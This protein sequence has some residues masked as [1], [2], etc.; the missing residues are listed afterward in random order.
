MTQVVSNSKGARDAKAWYNLPQM[1]FGSP[2][3]T[4]AP[5]KGRLLAAVVL[6]GL[7]TYLPYL[8]DGPLVN[9]DWDIGYR[10][11]AAPGYWP[12]YWSWFA[13]KNSNFSNRPVAPLIFA[14]QAKWFGY[15]APGYIALT[16]C[17]WL[18]AIAICV[19]SFGRAFGPVFAG[20]FTLLAF[21][22]SMASTQIFNPGMQIVGTSTM[23][24]WAASL[25][26]IWRAAESSRPGRWLLAS[27]LLLACAFLI[28]EL[29]LPLLVFQMFVPWAIRDLSGSRGELN[30]R[31]YFLRYLLPPLAIV[32]CVALLQKVVVPQ[33]YPVDSRLRVSPV[34]ALASVFSWFL[35][36]TV[37]LPTLW[38]ESLLYLPKMLQSP[39]NWLLL[40]ALGI[41]V[42]MLW[43]TAPAAQTFDDRTRQMQRR[44]S[45][46]AMLATLCGGSLYFMT[47]RSAF[48]W[49]LENRGLAST[50]V[51]LACCLAMAASLHADRRWVRAIVSMII[52][53]NAYSFCVQR[54]QY[55]QGAQVQRDVLSALSADAEQAELPQDSVLFGAVPEFL[56]DNFNDAV[57]FHAQ[58]DFNPASRLAT[59]DRVTV[60]VVMNQ[61]TVRDGRIQIIDD[62]R[63]DVSHYPRTEVEIDR[64][65]CFEYI[66]AT[67]QHRLF[68]V[69][70]VAHLRELMQAVEAKEPNPSRRPLLKPYLTDLRDLAKQI[71]R[72][73]K[74]QS[75]TATPQSVELQ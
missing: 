64:V 42:A 5:S 44:L 11:V 37:Q 48:V 23:L 40:A 74:K 19:R 63:L 31:Q 73:E 59:Q 16:L 45:A 34:N 75:P 18:P 15:W 46:V 30:G 66:Q 72:G 36:V 51:G 28:Y 65:W 1:L 61:R 13:E 22:P 68:K 54:E 3:H 20:V 47:G 71:I 56:P 17:C 38:I 58:R 27:N 14:A 12:S 53:I 26:T 7:L 2:T 52:L 62:R 69:R 41:A 70:D 49:G 24:L 29:I 55:R 57:V 33:F 35:A 6:V 32:F 50:W 67:K 4:T 39:L 10:S 60:G 43:R 21:S 9:D 25:G 8:Y